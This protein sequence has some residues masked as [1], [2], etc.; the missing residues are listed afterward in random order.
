[1]TRRCWISTVQQRRESAPK[2]VYNLEGCFMISFFT[3]C[4]FFLLLTV[5]VGNLVA[6]SDS[7]TLHC[8]DSS[9]CASARECREGLCVQQPLAEWSLETFTE[10]SRPD[11]AEP[12]T[13]PASN[14]RVYREPS[15]DDGGDG[16]HSF[17]QALL[18]SP[19]PLCQKDTRSSCYTGPSKTAGVGECQM[20]IRF[21][22]AD[23]VWSSCR[24]EVT[25]APEICD[26]KDNNCNGQIDEGM[27]PTPCAKQQGA[28]KGAVQRC[29][30]VQGWRLCEDADYLRH[31]SDYEAEETLC[32]NKDNNCDGHVDQL[33]PSQTCTIPGRKSDCA[34]GHKV[35]SK[36]QPVCRPIVTPQPFEVCGNKIDD[37]CDGRVDEADACPIAILQSKPTDYNV[38]GNG[39]VVLLTNLK[40]L[41]LQL[42]GAS[43]KPF[44]QLHID[45]TQDTKVL[46]GTYVHGFWVLPQSQRFVVLWTYLVKTN[47]TPWKYHTYLQFLDSSCNLVGTRQ[48]LDVSDF[49]SA[50]PYQNVSVAANDTFVVSLYDDKQGGRLFYFDAKGQSASNPMPTLPAKRSFCKNSNR[51]TNLFVAFNAKGQGVIVCSVKGTPNQ[52]IHFRRFD[53]NTLTFLDKQYRLLQASKSKTQFLLPPAIN[54][55]GAYRISW[56]ET[57]P[58]GR[59][60]HAFFDGAGQQQ[61]VVPQSSYHFHSVRPSVLGSDFLWGNESLGL[62]YRYNAKGQQVLVKKASVFSVRV[63]QQKKVYALQKRG[64][65]KLLVN[66]FSFAGQACQGKLCVC[67]PYE[68][69]SCVQDP[70][71]SRLPKPCQAGKQLCQ[72]DGLGWGPCLGEIIRT[73]EQC[74]DKKD[75]DC[76][77]QVDEGCSSLNT[78]TPPGLDAFDVG[79]DGSIVA[80]FWNGANLTGY[81][82]RNDRS[83]K[84]GFALVSSPF[85]MDPHRVVGY[86]QTS[87]S[88]RIAQQSGHIL[89]SWFERENTSYRMMSR[90][91]DAD[92]LPVT[93]PIVWSTS[94]LFSLHSGQKVHRTFIDDFGNFALLGRDLKNQ[95]QYLHLYNNKGVKMGKNIPLTPPGEACTNT[96]V[97]ALHPT[98]QT[99]M[100]VCLDNKGVP[101]YRRYH[102][103]R[104]FLDKAFVPLLPHNPLPSGRHVLSLLEFNHKG[105]IVLL[106]HRVQGTKS[107]TLYASFFDANV[108]FLTTRAYGSYRMQGAPFMTT[109]AKVVRWNNDF[110]FRDGG[111]SSRVVS[112]YRYSAK[113]NLISK[114][115][116]SSN[117]SFPPDTL[118]VSNNRT[119]LQTKFSIRKSLVT[120]K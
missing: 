106:S 81:C 96:P 40:V 104:G 21:C 99:I 69:R 13:E 22:E 18:D 108:K 33:G 110:V 92:C 101:Y 7:T 113:G 107:G 15:P 67:L 86:S 72:P 73:A 88:V 87:M 109:S 80:A 27:R 90:L 112:W 48:Q 60:V 89:F 16:E 100:I 98:A 36:G 17:E 53:A 103:S 26:G 58:S 75:N 12:P 116:F 38:L 79:K 61:A 68:Q 1:M 24:N 5:V 50:R 65:T 49:T 83:V 23:G 8:E 28:C 29:A 118:R 54:P 47:P 43:F 84:R 66:A 85:T 32:D 30:G 95:Q 3:R 117:D 41:C 31:S 34:R 39:S 56:Q 119:Y 46:D 62:W 97:A 74:G 51:E 9:N 6:C 37:N 82:Y 52:T 70:W 76:D 71:I 42:K 25:P 45:P 94:Y 63:S 20:G 2:V 120:F 14:E 64:S 114:G 115:Q 93:K 11:E 91:Y 44:K 105:E 4:C 10:P 19:S 55:Q 78:I 77:G 57:G 111:A 35:C 102:F 59:A